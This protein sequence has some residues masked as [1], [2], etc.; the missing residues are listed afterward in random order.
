MEQEMRQAGSRPKGVS[1]VQQMVERQARA[2]ERND[3]DL[4]AADWLPDG[5]LVAP[6][7]QW[8]GA[9]LRRVMAEFHVGFED[10][11]VGIRNVF[12]SP[13]ET[14]VAIEWDWAA[15]RESDGERSVT[16]DAII[17]SLVDGKISSWREYFDRLGSVE[18]P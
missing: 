10:V 8:S 7:G 12:M 13:D 5:V 11:E 1:V 14:Q 16:H 4:A 18:A 9:E 6:G 15:S 2:W 3:F 17:V